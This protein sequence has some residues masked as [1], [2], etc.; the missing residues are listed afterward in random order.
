[1]KVAFP[2]SLKVSLW[3]LLNLLLLAVLGCG[4]L[5][6]QGGLGWD[7]LVRG[8]AGERLQSAANLLATEFST[9]APAQIES[10][11]A[12]L[13]GGESVHFT[14]VQDFSGERR[15][16]AAL[17][18]PDAILAHLRAGQHG[19]GAP[20]R[21]GPPPGDLSLETP[22]PPLDG[23]RPTRAITAA[24]LARGRH[25]VPLDAP[26]GWWFIVRLPP[27]ERGGRPDPVSLVG[28]APSFP[29]V[30]RVLDLTPW[31]IASGTAVGVSILFWL[32]FVGG[33][34]GS[35]RRLGA[36]TERIAD[37]DF[38]TRVPATRRDELGQ[39]GDSVNRMA[40]RLDTLVNGQKKFLGDVAHEL[41][42][43]LGRLQV[44]IEILESRASPDLHPAVAD[45]R[46]EVQQLAALV[47]ELLA[48]TR[49][50]LRP[51]DAALSLVAVTSLV[52]DALEREAAAERVTVAVPPDL[53]VRA[54]PALLV[55]ALGNLV[56]NALRYAG[57][58][59]IRITAAPDGAALLLIV[60]DEGPGVPADALARL[61]EPFFR[62]ESARTR[63]TGG[64]GLGLSIV[65]S[66]VA[67]CGGEVQFR[68]RT[69]RGFR[70]EIRLPRL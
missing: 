3:L 10:A 21:L 14:L 67:A 40:G 34:T 32:P 1:M 16:G 33:I 39:L 22:P 35:L 53:T 25:L 58:S 69:P 18:L 11:L 59:A 61:G 30:L 13:P 44:A 60:E 9:A 37:G 4:A 31:W 26:A 52:R 49:A 65:R 19:P 66:C 68:N 42:S 12:R 56:R 64:V 5:V 62:P 2:L 45:V 28:F 54:D 23:P 20:D 17:Q 6:W 15:G 57:G 50:G 41:G 63:E 48:F 51:R 24:D 55:R 8:P 38:S 27:L 46:D 47:N 7:S 36:A 29:A 70:A 43:P